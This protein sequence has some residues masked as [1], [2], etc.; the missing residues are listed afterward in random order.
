M[1]VNRIEN[2][3]R[4]GGAGSSSSTDKSA[5]TLADIDALMDEQDGSEGLLINNKYN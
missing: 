3:V 1:C 5:V 4:L 2:L